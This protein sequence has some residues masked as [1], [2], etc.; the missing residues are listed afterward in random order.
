M[1]G[2]LKGLREKGVLGINGRNARFTLKY[3]PRRLYPLVDDKLRTKK[4]AQANGIP[5]PE[6]YALVE[7][8]GQVHELPEALGNYSDFVVKPAHGSGG[9]GIL[10]VSRASNGGLCKQDGKTISLD[11]FKH[12]VFNTLSG[13]YS[14]GGQPDEVLVEY[15]V[16]FDPLFEKIS[17]EGIPDIRIVV[18]FGV[19]TMAMVRLPTKESDGK[20]NLHQ[21]A[22]GVGICIAK[23]ATLR[24]VWKNDIVTEH[25]DTGNPVTGLTIPGWDRLLELSSMWYELTGLGYLGVDIVLD[26]TLGPLTL[27]LNARPGLNIQVANNCGLLPRLEMVER[28]YG[29]LK[30]VAQRVAFAKENFASV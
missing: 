29:D 12:H 5:I 18:M 9:E 28:Y 20:A 22:I 11:E 15:R 25:P 24:G 7:V 10:V 17:Y 27:E 3:N 23:G 26:K 21:G 1:F 6:L 30:N 14:L 4:L 19:P 16:E 8:A 2:I 13:L